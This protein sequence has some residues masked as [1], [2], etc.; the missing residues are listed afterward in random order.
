VLSGTQ[1]VTCCQNHDQIGNRMLGDRLSAMV[2]GEQLKVAAAVLLMTPSIPLLFMGEEYGES[3]PFLY[4]T[5]HSDT[6]LIDAVRKGRREEFAAFF[7][8]GEAPDPQSEDTFRRSRLT[9]TALSSE[10]EELANWYKSLLALRRKVALKEFSK[11]NTTAYASEGD[12]TLWILRRSEI[13]PS[14][15]VVSAFNFSAMPQD[16]TLP[17]LLSE[18][19]ILLASSKDNWND[20]I[21]VPRENFRP[22]KVTIQLPSFGVLI[23]SCAC[24]S[25]E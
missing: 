24:R 14:Q 12:R 15:V 17:F 7:E 3:A 9:W 6:G 8:Q 23:A 11:K 19:S 25:Q 20:R 1:L 22:Y 21:I 16:I 10:Q 2:S 18:W 5:S 13:D 4:F